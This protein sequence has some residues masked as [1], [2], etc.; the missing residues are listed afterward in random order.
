VTS[1]K[2]DY[3]DQIKQKL[4]DLNYRWSIE[5]NKIEARAQVETAEALKKFEEKRE[6]LRKFRKDMEKK[7]ADLEVSGESAWDDIKIGAEEAWDKLSK[8][9]EKASSHFKK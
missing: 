2:E 9:F 6:D 4:D 8:A 1:P 7:I 5:R 3:L